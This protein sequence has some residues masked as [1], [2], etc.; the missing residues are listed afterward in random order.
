MS[1]LC[2]SRYTKC[3]KYTINGAVLMSLKA[4]ICSQNQNAFTKETHCH[5]C[6]PRNSVTQC[7]LISRFAIHLLR[8]IRRNGFCDFAN[9]NTRTYIRDVIVAR[10]FLRHAT[11]DVIETFILDKRN[12]ISR[13]NA[14]SSSLLIIITRISFSRRICPPFNVNAN[15][16][17]Y[18][19]HTCKTT[20][21]R[22]IMEIE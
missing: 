3:I 19:Q 11:L 14:I 15:L 6:L 9:L 8:I 16:A 20:C 22:S 2:N 10:L 13:Y 1:L 17:K 5:R 12:I 18:F 7:I 4:P 21:Y